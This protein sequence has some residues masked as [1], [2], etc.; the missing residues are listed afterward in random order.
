MP[1][2]KI[3]L[4][5]SPIDRELT[6][7]I[8]EDLRDH[9]EIGSRVLVPFGERWK[10]GIVVDLC[11]TSDIPSDRVKAIGQILDPYPLIT[12]SMLQLCQWI[13]HYYLCTLSHVLTAA[14]PSGIHLD[15]G[16]HFA[17]ENDPPVETLAPRQRDIINALREIESASIRQLERRLGKQGVKS[18]IYGLLRR[19][20]L[21]AFQKMAAPRV[22]TKTERLVELVPADARWFDLELPTLEKRAPR[23]A[24]CI[25]RLH[26][27]GHP[28]PAL[29]LSTEG[30]AP[31]VLKSLANRNLVRF[32]NREV[33]R[34]PYAHEDLPPP[35]DVTL[36]PHQSESIKAITTSISSN[37]FRVHLLHGV[38]GSGKTLVYIQAVAHALA[39]NKGAIV[40]V[41][42]I[43]LTP[44]TVRRF[45]T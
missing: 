11:E 28:L 5:G 39:S 25:R 35:E 18:A 44:Q 29:Q 24:E 31:G 3:V 37:T 23:Q 45:R 16:Q 10:T 40:L 42:E 13:S 32:I 21:V 2:A 15:S 19:G 33:V 22:K 17:I 30:I 1:Y 14:L 27:A 36:T 12:P 38:T 8:P 26:A 43:T 4:L 41:P 6:Y 7:N 9:L 34:D 20:T